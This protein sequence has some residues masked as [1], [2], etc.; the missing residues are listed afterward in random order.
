VTLLYSN[1]TEDS[2]ED[3]SF[4]FER[5]RNKS[6]GPS[7]KI[8]IFA[9]KKPKKSSILQALPGMDNK[10][11]LQKIIKSGSVHQSITSAKPGIDLWR[12]IKDQYFEE[13]V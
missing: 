11:D 8:N 6:K 7:R 13:D 9:N 5:R 1:N 3:S 10:E 12:N 2:K 4:H